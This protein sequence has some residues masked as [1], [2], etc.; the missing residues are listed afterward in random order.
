MN[1]ILSYSPEVG[2]ELL[3]SSVETEFLR[4]DSWLADLIR[5]EYNNQPIS[6]LGRDKLKRIEIEMDIFLF[7]K[8]QHDLLF[9][10]KAA[11]L[12]RLRTTRSGDYLE[13]LVSS[14]FRI[15]DNDLDK[16]E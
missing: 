12:R 15:I 1:A 4:E 11:N 6:F 2:P 8:I 16:I 14:R 7:D 3:S 5:R 9:V 13:S 10:M